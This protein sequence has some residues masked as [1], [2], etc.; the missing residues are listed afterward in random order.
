MGPLTVSM[1]S[2]TEDLVIPRDD[3]KVVEATR[4]L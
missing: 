4:T 1:K 2:E 3:E